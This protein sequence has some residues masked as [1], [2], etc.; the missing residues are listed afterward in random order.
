MACS[1]LSLALWNE[2]MGDE[3]EGVLVDGRIVLADADSRGLFS[4]D[5]GADH[6]IVAAELGQRVIRLPDEAFLAIFAGLLEGLATGGDGDVGALARIER[7]F[8]EVGLEAAG[9]EEGG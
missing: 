7:L 8:H 9:L 3:A 2:V 1:F 4:H 6:R 5:P